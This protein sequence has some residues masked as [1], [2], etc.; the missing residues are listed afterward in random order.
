MTKD[1]HLSSQPG[2][3]SRDH[4]YTSGSNLMKKIIR[5]NQYFLDKASRRIDALSDGHQV[6]DF[7]TFIQSV[8]L[9]DKALLELIAA[10]V[11]HA[12][13]DGRQESYDQKKATLYNIILSIAL[14]SDAFKQGFEAEY[15]QRQHDGIFYELE[16]LLHLLVP[17]EHAKRLSPLQV[18]NILL[19]DMKHLESFIQILLDGFSVPKFTRAYNPDG[20]NQSLVLYQAEYTQDI[21]K[22]YVDH[23]VKYFRSGYNLDALKQQMN[24][25]FGVI[26]W[27]KDKKHLHSLISVGDCLNNLDFQDLMHQVVL[28]QSMVSIGECF[29]NHALSARAKAHLAHDIPTE[30]WR[31]LRN[32]LVHVAWHSKTQTSLDYW[33]QSIL[34][35]N[36]AK[37]TFESLVVLC[38]TAV[39]KTR[40]FYEQYFDKCYEGWIPE[41]APLNRPDPL[42]AQTLKFLMKSIP[43][44]I[45]HNS[46]DEASLVAQYHRWGNSSRQQLLS[47][48][49][50]SQA[51]KQYKRK[52]KHKYENL[53]SGFS[54]FYNRHK[55]KCSV[56][57]TC[58]NHL[59]KG[60]GKNSTPAPE[61]VQANALIEVARLEQWVGLA[62]LKQNKFDLAQI[63]R[64]DPSLYLAASFQ[65][66]LVY[67]H[68]HTLVDE[69]ALTDVERDEWCCYRNHLQH[70]HVILDLRGPG[71]QAL[72]ASYCLKLFTEIKPKLQSIKFT[73]KPS[74]SKQV[75]RFF[76]PIEVNARTSPTLN[77][78]I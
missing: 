26:T 13:Q 6:E 10:N 45:K 3:D 39:S 63:L 57:D 43:E 29:A 77:I 76:K 55:K 34:I 8:V 66:N 68:I 64:N 61:Q 44:Q 15:G 9:D 24:H 7:P 46:L 22:C 50:D 27:H 42:F 56:H 37:I 60:S 30:G 18:D 72:L 65:V 49:T 16:F 59:S 54:S 70:G 47:K 38:Q 11:Q 62:C 21:D 52:N 41:A 20:S 12:H 74:P 35:K 51:L 32:A 4:L 48:V 53:V 67:E 14:L 36:K 33:R 1:L 2:I 69:L 19:L 25:S 31:Q 75:G 40:S 58:I 28:F 71:A 23:V 78:S 17:D 5:R 73:E